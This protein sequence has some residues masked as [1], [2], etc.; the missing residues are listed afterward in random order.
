M[1][2]YYGKTY[3]DKRLDDQ[4]LHEWSQRWFIAIG[5]VCLGAILMYCLIKYM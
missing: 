2:T 4:L 5:G 1:K 3:G